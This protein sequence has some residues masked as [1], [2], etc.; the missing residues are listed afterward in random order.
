[1]SHHILIVDDQQ[2]LA[3]MLAQL[4]DDAGYATRTAF[5]AR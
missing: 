3:H 4:L 2:E 5:D 1:M